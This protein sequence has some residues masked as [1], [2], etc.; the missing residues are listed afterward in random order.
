MVQLGTPI[1]LGHDETRYNILI[2]P[3]NHISALILAES[4]LKHYIINTRNDSLELLS[5]G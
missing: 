2:H 1:I 3:I 5:T 4:G